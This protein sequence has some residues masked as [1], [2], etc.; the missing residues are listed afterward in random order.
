MSE[1]AIRTRAKDTQLFFL[2]LN[3]KIIFYFP[4]K[5]Y[6]IINSI[7]LLYIIKI[8]LFFLSYDSYEFSSVGGRGE[9]FRE[10]ER[11]REMGVLQEEEEIWRR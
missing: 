8:Y 6:L 3:N 2:N 4:I 11:E 10:R 5:I 9:N 1:T 7:I